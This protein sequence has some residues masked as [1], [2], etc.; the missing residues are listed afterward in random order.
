MAV[1]DQLG[2][3]EPVSLVGQSMGAHTA[4]LMAAAYPE[5]VDRLVMVEGGVGGGGT[6]VVR[7]LG[8]WL[9]SWPVPFPDRETATAWFVGGGMS[10]TAATAWAEGLEDRGGELWPRFDQEVMEITLGFVAQR[11]CWSEWL[12]TTQPALLV[13]G[14]RSLIAP[15]EVM[16][17]VEARP[18]VTAVC[19]PRAGHDLHLDQVDAW[20]SVLQDFLGLPLPQHG[21]QR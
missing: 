10:V 20:I 5:L 11:R 21:R 15:A 1:I 6:A 2:S 14:E 9:R 19:V 4:M 16:R 17:M 18:A 8:A 13:L 3:G 7:R 12:G